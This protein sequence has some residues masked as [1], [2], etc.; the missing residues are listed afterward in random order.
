M[1]GT[2]LKRWKCCVCPFALM[3]KIWG[4]DLCNSVTAFRPLFL[5]SVS[6]TD[7]TAQGCLQSFKRIKKCCRGLQLGMQLFFCP[8]TPTPGEFSSSVNI[9]HSGWVLNLG[10]VAQ[11]VKNLPAMRATRVPSEVRTI[12]W[13]REQ[14]LA[15]PGFLPG[16][17]RG[18]RSWQ[19]TGHG[20]T[21][22]QTMS[23]LLRVRSQRV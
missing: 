15:T 17:L 11:K 14:Q 4:V 18:Q 20:V 10:L 1:C 22:S 3:P 6:R 2:C 23:E 5:P 16:E 7:K 8:P 13:R 19:A 9:A 21:K 12:P